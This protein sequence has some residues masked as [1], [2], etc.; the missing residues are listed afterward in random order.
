MQALQAV[1]S[2][3]KQHLPEIL[4]D[5]QASCADHPWCSMASQDRLNNLAE[6]VRSLVDAALGD[7]PKEASRLR[8]VREAAKH[9]EHRLEMGFSEPVLLT[10]YTLLYQALWR[11]IQTHFPAPLAYAAITRLDAAAF[12]TTLASLN[13]FH[14][15]EHEQEGFWPAAIKDFMERRHA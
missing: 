10:E 3:I 8:K 12:G 5:W 4:E 13:V 15:R 14:G 7:E 1:A 2:A 11:F 9:G 6:V